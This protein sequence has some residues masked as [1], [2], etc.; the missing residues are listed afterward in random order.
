MAS[1]KALVVMPKDKLVAVQD[2][3]IPEPG[4]SEILIQVSAVALN[5]VDWL[6]TA[7]PVA[8]QDRRVVGSD[9]A[10]VVTNCLLYTSPS[11][12]D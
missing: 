3:P 7:N 4:P 10:G 9:F 1:M 8:A 11:P 5:I 2:M 6:Y 12:R